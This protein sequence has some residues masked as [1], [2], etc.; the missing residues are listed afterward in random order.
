MRLLAAGMSDRWSSGVLL[1]EMLTGQRPFKGEQ[2]AV[3]MLSILN[4]G[5]PEITQFQP[6]IALPLADLVHLCW[7][8]QLSS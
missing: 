3:V 1:Y 6:D 8:L 7:L 5:V 2:L 4:D